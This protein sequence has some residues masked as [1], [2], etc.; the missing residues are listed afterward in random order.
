MEYRIAPGALHKIINMKGVTDGDVYKILDIDDKDV[1]QDVQLLIALLIES[2][3]HLNDKLE[4][5]K[6]RTK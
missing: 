6:E 4:D 5:V 1:S 3:K 2:I